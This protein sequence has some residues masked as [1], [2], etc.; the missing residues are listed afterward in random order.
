M[1]E[2]LLIRL[3]IEHKGFYSLRH[4]FAARALECGI[5]VKTLLEILGHKNANVTLNRYVHSHVE[6]KQ[7]IMNLV[8]K[9]IYATQSKRVGSYGI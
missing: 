5:D 6:H 3:G 4:T 9:L 1:F 2:R 8:G 7:E